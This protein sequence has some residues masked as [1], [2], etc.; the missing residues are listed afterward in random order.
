MLRQLLTSPQT[1]GRL[2]MLMLSLST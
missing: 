2:I 1:D